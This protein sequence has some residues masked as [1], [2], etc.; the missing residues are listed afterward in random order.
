MG[1]KSDALISFQ[2]KHTAIV[3]FAMGFL[4]LALWIVLLV[5]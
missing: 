3:R 1:M 2:K 4:F 5:A